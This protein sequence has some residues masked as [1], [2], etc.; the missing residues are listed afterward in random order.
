[1]LVWRC[2]YFILAFLQEKK[3]KKHLNSDLGNKLTWGNK[4]LDFE[5]ISLVYAV[6]LIMIMHKCDSPEE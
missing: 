6:F 2:F 3:K 4:S 5:A 1:M